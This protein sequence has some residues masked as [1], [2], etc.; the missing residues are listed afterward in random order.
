MNVTS[1]LQRI[2]INPTTVEGTNVAPVAYDANC[3]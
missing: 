1:V 2:A 3:L